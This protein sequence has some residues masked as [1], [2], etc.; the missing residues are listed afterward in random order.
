[1]LNYLWTGFFFA[2]AAATLYQGMWLGHPEIF[3]LVIE[4]VF[5]MAKTAFEI[6][7][8]LTG[9]MTFWLG[10][11]RVGERAGC[12][13]G[14]SRAIAPVLERLFPEIPAGHP[15][16]GSMVMNMAA[17]VLGLDNAA[18]PLG[19]KAMQELQELNPSADTASNSQI[20]FY[21]INASSITLVPV[22][23][24]TILHQLGYR[25]PTELFLPILLA[26]T[27]ST[28]V[29]VGTACLFQ[30]I[31]L[32][33]RR[34]LLAFAGALGLVA[35][36][37]ALLPILGRDRLQ[38]AAGTA[39]SAVIFG[40][41]IFFI[42]LAALRKV[43][44]YE[45]FIAGAKEGFSVTIAIVPYLVA[46][47]V[48]V[49]VLR[50][51]G[52]LDLALDAIAWLAGL[53]SGASGGPRPA[54]I[55]ALPTGFMKPFSGS[56]ARA[57]MIETIKTHGVDSLA[58]RMAA[59]MQGCTE[60]TFYVL[61]VYFGAVGIRRTRYAVTCGLLADAAGIIAAIIVTLLFFG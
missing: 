57:L 52:V 61:A 29:G 51:S 60:T 46:M 17:N 25:N 16:F 40:L 44:V 23:V 19:L 28:V 26:T 4:S 53:F 20:M 8:G 47:L 10:I 34:I 56:G 39:G 50:A 55:E 11:M 12:I 18:T 45:E 33:E 36:L 35:G 7:L 5:A 22:G 14:L 37:A 9:V 6:A 1:M 59:V 32:F 13:R 48:A 38:V 21:A 42:G 31:N 41:I 43:N 49:G 27:C 58:G 30:R 2:A 24:F 3:G 15:A 54:F